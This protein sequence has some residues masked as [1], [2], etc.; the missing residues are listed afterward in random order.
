MHVACSRNKSS[1]VEI[2]EIAFS[3]LLNIPTIQ[4]LK[5]YKKAIDSKVI[6][7]K[8]LKKLAEDADVPYPLFF[9]PLN[10]VRSQIKRVEK[11]VM[12][13]LPTKNEMRLATRGDFNYDAIRLIAMD[14]ARKQLLLKRIH[15]H[16]GTLK[17]NKII[18]LLGKKYSKGYSHEDIAFEVRKTLNIDASKTV[19]KKSEMLSYLISKIEDCGVLVSMS[20]HNFMPQNLDRNISFSGFCMRDKHFPFVFINTRDGDE[21]PLIYESDGRKV[22]TL[23]SMIVAIMIGRFAVGVIK[24]DKKT[25]P[26][27]F[28]INRI[29]GMVLIP[30]DDARLPVNRITSLD[31]VKHVANVFKVTPSMALER[32]YE[33]KLVTKSDQNYWR[34]QLFNARP[35]KQKGGKTDPVLAYKKYNGTYFSH[36][37]IGAYKK[38]IIDQRQ[39][40]GA[41]FKHGR[42]DGKTMKKFVESF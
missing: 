37:I 13:K 27:L 7:L 31:E 39:L 33:L 17:N 16:D 28:N 2:D 23:V 34:T 6:S 42:V 40:K 9:A 25:Q 1:Y 32:L 14:L 24:P 26:D 18:G 21:E 22:F 38:K 41:L 36:E 35:K 3:L 4:S 30:G 12:E 10:I 29:T 8:K 5:D 11:E 15:S 20:A 19:K